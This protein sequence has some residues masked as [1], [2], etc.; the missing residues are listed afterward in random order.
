MTTEKNRLPQDR[1]D[2]TDLHVSFAGLPVSSASADLVRGFSGDL[3]ELGEWLREGFVDGSSWCR[4]GDAV[5][6]VSDG[7]AEMRLVPR[8]DAPSWHADYFQA[9][10]GSSEGAR[11]PPE[12]RLQYA[13]YVDRRHKAR[14]SCLQGEDLRAV[15]ATDGARGVDKLVRHHRA[16]LV[17]W[18][19][20]LDHLLHS[21]Q[22]AS[23]LPEWATSVAKDELL[24]WHRT[25]EHLT[26]AV[27]EYHHGDAEP[28]PETV[29]GNLCFHFSTGSVELVPGL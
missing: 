6:T 22:T 21:V 19:D 25:R 15:A 10:W 24:D 28:R 13:E 29:F 18:Y 8:S 23:D 4:V 9:G 3:D 5:H 17:E 7:A 26:S 14:E 2:I 11:I 12:F 1:V 27:L 20:A 16:Q